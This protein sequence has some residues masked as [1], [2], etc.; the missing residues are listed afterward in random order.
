LGVKASGKILARFCGLSPKYR[1]KQKYKDKQ[2]AAVSGII[3]NHFHWYR[4]II[5]EG[6]EII[7]EERI[8]STLF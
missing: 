5:D 7:D 2:P 8:R 1:L 6:H 4:I 3:L